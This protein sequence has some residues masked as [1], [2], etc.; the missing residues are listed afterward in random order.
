MYNSRQALEDEVIEYIV[1]KYILKSHDFW[2]QNGTH[3][4]TVLYIE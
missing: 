2:I 4:A 3:C 1:Y